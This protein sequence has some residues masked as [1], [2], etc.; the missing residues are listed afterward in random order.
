MV[1]ALDKFFLLCLDVQNEIVAVKKERKSANGNLRFKLHVFGEDLNLV[2]QRNEQL[3]IPQAQVI[4][5]QNSRTVSRENLR[6]YYTGY[7]EGRPGSSLAVKVNNGS[8]V[9][10]VL[11][12]FRP[13]LHYP[14]LSSNQLEVCPLN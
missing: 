8:L 9:C 3:T 2:L 12:R 10:D 11:A 7:L 5:R 13:Y 1:H 6:N 14:N 4:R